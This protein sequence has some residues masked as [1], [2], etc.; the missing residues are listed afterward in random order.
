MN[1]IG[2][3]LKLPAESA[4][5]AL[6]KVID[7]NARTYTDD[8]LGSQIYCTSWYT[9]RTEIGDRIWEIWRIT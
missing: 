7:W 8:V 4:P 3:Y 1:S 9:I 5:L 2:Q 6:R